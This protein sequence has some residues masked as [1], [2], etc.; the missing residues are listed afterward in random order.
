MAPN[1]IV[2]WHIP[3]NGSF[4]LGIDTSLEPLDEDYC[5]H[6]GGN[7]AHNAAYC[8]MVILILIIT[9]KFEPVIELSKNK[10]IIDICNSVPSAYM[11]FKLNSPSSRNQY[12]NL[13]H[14][15]N[16]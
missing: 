13:G 15:L 7:D 6:A 1:Q 9:N 5:D 16:K 14:L 2:F 12:S 10:Y 3:E 4:F 11:E 8:F